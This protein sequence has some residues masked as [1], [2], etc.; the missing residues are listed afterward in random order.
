VTSNGD[1]P[2]TSH[3]S[4]TSLSFTTST[5]FS[6]L[7]KVGGSKDLRGREKVAYSREDPSQLGNTA[8]MESRF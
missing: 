5:G 1:V 7:I 3:S 4:S 8:K 2:V 6:S